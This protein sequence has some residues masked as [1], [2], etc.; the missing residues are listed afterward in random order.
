LAAKF[1]RKNNRHGVAKFKA[2]RKAQLRKMHD[3]QPK[4]WSL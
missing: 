2:W 4:N 3:L 1:H